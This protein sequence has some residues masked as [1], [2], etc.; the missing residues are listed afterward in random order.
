MGSFKKNNLILTAFL[1]LVF[2]SFSAVADSTHSLNGLADLLEYNGYDLVRPVYYEEYSSGPTVIKDTGEVVYSPGMRGKDCDSTRSGSD[3]TDYQAR[4][5]LFDQGDRREVLRTAENVAAKYPESVG[6][7]KCVYN[8]R[9]YI[10]GSGSLVALGGDKFTTIVTNAHIFKDLKS[11]I[12][13]ND[14]EITFNR[15]RRNRNGGETLVEDVIKIP[16]GK[17]RLI[18]DQRL[19]DGDVAFVKIDNR[20]ALEKLKYYGKM[21]FGF[22]E[23]ADLDR[24]YRL[25][26]II[27]LI[28]YSREH[29]AIA[30]SREGCKIVQRRPGDLTYGEKGV[31]INSCDQ[32][33]GSSG[34]ILVA[35]LNNQSVILG[36]NF[37]EVVDREMYP[38]DPEKHKNGR[39]NNLPF[40]PR[41]YTGM[42]ISL[43]SPTLKGFYD[44]LKAEAEGQ[45]L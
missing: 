32:N 41:Y 18:G 39:P 31:Y 23:E 24:L 30:V 28:A 40:D 36:V 45:S 25:G 42:A 1:A 15:V 10:R 2:S 3:L 12:V 7:I 37:G 35:T 8:G 14:C 44:Q 38:H 6:I 20:E 29:N 34:G 4:K 33:P 9:T 19:A 27:E 21:N 43:E 5:V 22:V 26:T 13:F 17:N 11:G 16:A